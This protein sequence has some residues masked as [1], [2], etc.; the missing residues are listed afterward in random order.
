MNYDSTKVVN[1]GQETSIY[2]VFS[3]MNWITGCPN[4][5]WIIAFHYKNIPINKWRRNYRI[6]T[7]QWMKGSRHWIST[8]ANTIRETTRHEVPPD[9][10]T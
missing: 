10:R 8:A 2:P 9:E 1:T 6:R 4:S 5:I 7:P 3:Y